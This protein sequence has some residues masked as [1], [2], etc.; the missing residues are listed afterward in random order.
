M[1]ALAVFYVRDAVTAA[2][3]AGAPVQLDASHARAIVRALRAGT[4]HALAERAAGRPTTSRWRTDG[5]VSVAR[6]H[7]PARAKWAPAWW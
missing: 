2:L 1:L 5:V 3:P 6:L 7:G 4:R